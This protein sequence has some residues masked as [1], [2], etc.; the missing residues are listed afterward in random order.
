MKQ[1]EGAVGGD[2]YW[3][4]LNLDKEE[5]EVKKYKNA[6][7]SLREPAKPRQGR[8]RS[9]KNRRMLLNL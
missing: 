4:L 8:S 3:N 1:E 7:R 5:N 9:R 6:I 2:T